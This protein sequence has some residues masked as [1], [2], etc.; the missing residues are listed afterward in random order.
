VRFTWFTTLPAVATVTDVFAGT[1]DN[2][3]MGGD[4]D[5]VKFASPLYWALNTTSPEGNA[6]A[7]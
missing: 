6:L 3:R 2:T 7:V 5:W 4:A 1:T